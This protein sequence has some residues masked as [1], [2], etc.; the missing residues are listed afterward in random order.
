MKRNLNIKVK[1]R[2]G[3]DVTEANG[4]AGTYADYVVNALD[5]F[6]GKAPDGVTKRGFDALSAR[7]FAAKSPAKDLEL[8]AAEVEII[9]A[10]LDSSPY[11][12]FIV[13]QIARHLEAK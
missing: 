2:D 10:A 7:V 3:K 5:F 1:T 4:K 9:V 8:S 6:N 12:P 13:G 11:P